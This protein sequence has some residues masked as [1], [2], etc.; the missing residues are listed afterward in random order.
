MFL[1][2]YFQLTAEDIDTIY[3]L[4]ENKLLWWRTLGSLM[5]PLDK[6]E[7]ITKDVIYGVEGSLGTD[8]W[9]AGLDAQPVNRSLQCPGR[10]EGPEETVAERLRSQRDAS[11][12][13]K[14]WTYTVENWLPIESPRTPQSWSPPGPHYPSSPVYVLSLAPQ[15]EAPSVASSW[16]NV[17]LTA[18]VKLNPCILGIPTLPSLTYISPLSTRGLQNYTDLPQ[19]W[20]YINGFNCLPLRTRSW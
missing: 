2:F 18:A 6:D 1:K 10:H 11:R 17:L 14:T 5:E 8:Y 9:E 19:L 3:L 20:T 13:D 16:K 4:I 12:R 7:W 15:T